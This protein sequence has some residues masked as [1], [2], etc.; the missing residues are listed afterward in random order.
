MNLCYFDTS[1]LLVYTLASGKEAERYVHVKKLFDLI[2]KEEIKAITSFYALHELYIFAPEQAPDFEI[3]CQYG[4]DA[5]NLILTTKIQVTPL[6]NRMKKL[7]NQR[8]FTQLADSTDM[9]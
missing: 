9:P 2:E 5:L 8:L 3:G 4:K 1:V 6:L 7:I